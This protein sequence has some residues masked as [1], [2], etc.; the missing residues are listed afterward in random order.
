MDMTGDKDMDTDTSTDKDTDMDKHR[1]GHGHGY[2]IGR[3][4]GKGH[5]HGNGQ[6]LSVIGSRISVKGLV[7]YESDI[8]S[9]TAL[10]SPISEITISD[11]DHKYRTECLPMLITNP[12]ISGSK[13]SGV[14]LMINC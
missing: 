4:P 10:F 14:P 13:I 11:S 12:G 5:G 8:M 3:G 7:V 6:E 2:G 9:N 1:H